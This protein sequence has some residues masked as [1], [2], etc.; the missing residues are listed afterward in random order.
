MGHPVKIEFSNNSLLGYLENLNIPRNLRR[1]QAE[2][3][4][5]TIPYEQDT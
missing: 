1:K 2:L 5:S 3:R 4:F